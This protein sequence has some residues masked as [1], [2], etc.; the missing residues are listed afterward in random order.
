MLTGDGFHLITLIKESLIL[1][2]PSLGAIVVKDQ[3]VVVATIA[4]GPGF[5]IKAAHV[6]FSPNIKVV[7]TNIKERTD[8][9]LRYIKKSNVEIVKNVKRIS[10]SLV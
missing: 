6:S 1:N 10:C 7:Y 5:D 2:R 9:E 4:R 3:L 8:A